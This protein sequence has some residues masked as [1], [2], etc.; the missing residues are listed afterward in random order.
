VHVTTLTNVAAATG[1]TSHSV[2][3]KQDGAVYAMGANTV[4]QIGDGTTTQRKTP[5]AVSNLSSVV[6]TATRDDHSLALTEDGAVYS[7]GRNANGQLGD[8]STTTRTSPVAIGGEDTEWVLAAPTVTPASGSYG[9]T[10]TVAMTHPVADALLRYTL[11]GSEPTLDSLT[12]SAAFAVSYDVTVKAKAFKLGWTDSPT[13]T[14]AY[15]FAATDTT[16]PT[17]SAAVTPAPNAAGW[18]NVPPTVT[19]TCS[20]A[21]SGIASCPAAKIV[22]QE[23]ASLVISG[24]AVDKA[25]NTATT[26]ATVKVDRTPPILT[27]SAPGADD[28]V[29]TGTSVVTVRGSVMEVGSGIASLT[30]N[31]ATAAIVGQGYTCT[32]SVASG[33][34]VIT[35][36]AVDAAGHIAQRQVTVTVGAVP[37]PQALVVSPA[38]LT[39][40]VGEVRRLRVTDERGRDVTDS[41]WS[42]QDE[43]IAE[44][45]VTAGVVEVHAL[46]AGETTLT[47]TRGGLEAD[48]TLTVLAASA[49]IPVGT[50][51]WSLAPAPGSGGAVPKRAQVLRPPWQNLPPEVEQPGLFFIDEGASEW[52]A[53]WWGETPWVRPFDRPT[54]ITATTPDGRQLWQRQFGGPVARQFA[55]DEYGGLVLLM[56]HYYPPYSYEPHFLRRYDGVTGAVSWE[57]HAPWDSNHASRVSPFAIAADGRVFLV[58]TRPG[59][60]RDLIA[61]DGET[62][63]LVGRWPVVSG[64]S[65]GATGPLVLEDGSVVLFTT[66]RVSDTRELRRVVLGGDPVTLTSTVVNTSALTAP[67][68]ANLRVN[69]FQPMPD[70]HGGVLLRPW[71]PARASF[72]YPT[73]HREV[74][75]V[76]PAGILSAPLTLVPQTLRMDAVY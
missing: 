35:V 63:G 68:A 10:Q 34:N 48:V 72:S 31:S 12:Y 73:F 75:R 36:S 40:L 59:D 17:I 52:D 2:V 71:T 49:E 55:A 5:V 61:L 76:S 37:A 56:E 47:V 1:G 44:V 15:T 74:Y 42:V 26:N 43:L 16:P 33:A 29:P 62:G 24:T 21:A 51:L 50:S 8:N 11:D 65:S 60:Q 41:T 28:T 7:W 66:A 6:Q 32:V 4:G 27:I 38:S 69:Y 39:L 53:N 45:T 3:R 57:Y 67:Q 70:G 9:T 23:G 64:P 58:E 46:A 19:F 30:C 13:V 14:R 18:H 20:D 22:T 25:G 54:T